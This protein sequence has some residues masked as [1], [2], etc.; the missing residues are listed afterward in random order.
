MILSIAIILTGIVAV[1][2]VTYFY[3][4]LSRK[5]DE[6]KCLSK[7]PSISIL[8]PAYNEEKV[9][10]NRI[11]NLAESDYPL[12][13]MELIIVNDASKDNTEAVALKAMEKYGLKGRVVKNKTRSGVNFSM[14]R[15]IKEAYLR[16]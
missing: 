12:E 16:T 2:Y 10:D 15:G 11:K 4:S 9:I 3:A 6:L 8:F 14:S 5:E 13:K 1:V 7:Y